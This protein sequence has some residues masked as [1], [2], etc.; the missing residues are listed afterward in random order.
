MVILQAHAR[1]SKGDALFNLNWKF[2]TGNPANAQSPTFNDAS[3]QTVCV[4]HSASYDAPPPGDG[5]CTEC[6]HY[7]G[8]F[9][10]RK[11]F[12]CP[13]NVKKVFIQFEGV[14]QTATVF[15]NGN[16]VGMHDNSGYTG[17]F[18]DI[19]NS[20]TR[21][22][23]TV[24]AVHGN[25]VY[26]TSIPPGGTGTSG[27]PDY[28]L[29]SGIYRNVRLLFKDSVYVPLR[30]QRIT[31][32]SSTIR[33]LT[34]VNNDGA[35]SKSVTVACT[36][37]N[38]GGASVGTATATQSV[39]ANGAY[40]FD[41]SPTVSSPSLWSATTPT[42]YSVETMVSVGGA[43]VDS[44]VEKV[45]FR[46]YTWSAGT[47]GGLSVNGTR[48]ELKG[49][50]LA[51]F[52]GW[53]EN[54]VPDS[55][56]A[57]QVT[58]MKE[59]GVNSI[60]CSHYPRA[61]A[62][63]RACDSVGMM[64]LVEAPNWGVNGGFANNAPFWANMYSCDSEMVLDGYNHP[65]IWGWS[66]FNE[67]SETNLGPFFANESAIV[68]Q[69]DP[70]AGSGRVTLI[71]NYAA[72][73]IYPLDIF[74]LNYNTSNSTSI[75][76]VNTEDY[77]NWMRD[78]IRG[79]AMDLDVGGSSEASAEVKQMTNDWSTSD[80]CGGAHFWCFQD[81]C[82]WR[83]TVGRE[84]LVDRLWIPKNVYYMFKNSLTGGAT[85]YWTNGTPATVDLKA[86]LTTLKADGAD[87]SQIVA[88]LRDASNKVVQ[89]SAG[90]NITFAVTGPAT[91]F[92]GTGTTGNL[93]SASVT[94]Q[95]GRAGALLRTTSTA[96]AI[97]VT[98]TSSCGLSVATV[99]LTSTPVT[100]NITTPISSQQPA[101]RSQG[102]DISKQL[103]ISYSG[104]NAIVNFPVGVEKTVR[105]L[106]CQG[107]TMA[108]AML[109][110][111]NKIVVDRSA[112]ENGI[113]YISWNI[114]GHKILSMVNGVR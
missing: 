114:N 109:K 9:W 100:E 96:G 35:V 41:L 70:V 66:L 72:N 71:S 10:Y 3:W 62:F 38:S 33:A 28:L 86:D 18:F 97:T 40:A 19:S 91:L 31:T 4:P 102:L 58:M 74:G 63:Y 21:G 104:K 39:P 93:T 108:T 20:V 69:F 37:R 111:G 25:V 77:Q 65:S 101:L 48:T 27:A 13:S 95:G 94:V 54:A 67:P 57:K 55:R 7:Q 30:G 110:D 5:G 83:N 29:Y 106:N 17:F 23:S 12:L 73:V 11:S 60:R 46:T 45:G 52:M 76:I 36:V 90:C 1:T 51:Q 92:P 79:S 80:K 107:R 22:A 49:M 24:I 44:V 85:D 14:M 84:G 68:H 8:D 53:I 56:F 6:K 34:N 64:V 89:P 75:P 50:C 61:E 81:Y 112:M 99:N 113:L 2:I 42:L 26:S 32:T 43:V 16:Q 88:T 78:F 15:V 47:P 98:A 105:L 87:I 59:M 103:A 82:S